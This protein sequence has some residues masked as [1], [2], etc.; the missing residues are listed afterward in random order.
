[1]NCR[2]IT[3]TGLKAAG[4]NIMPICLM[5]L[6][7]LRRLPIGILHWENRLIDNALLQWVKIWRYLWL[8]N[9]QVVPKDD[10]VYDANEI[11]YRRLL[12]GMVQLKE[13]IS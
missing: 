3:D 1:M 8:R 4:I 12:F 6:P 2:W 11:L 10:F 13:Q 9:R 5:R 7:I